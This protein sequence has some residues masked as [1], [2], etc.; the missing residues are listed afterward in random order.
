M[1]TLYVLGVYDSVAKAFTQMFFSNNVGIASREF[2]DCCNNDK[3]PMSKHA[4]DFSLYLFGSVNDENGVFS[5][6]K[7][8]VRIV[9]GFD[10]ISEKKDISLSS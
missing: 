5:L 1:A 10:C 8:P 4:V 3:L 9:S 7:E 6:E 2:G